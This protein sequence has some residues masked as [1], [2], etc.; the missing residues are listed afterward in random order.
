V[1]EGA[2]CVGLLTF[3]IALMAITFVEETFSRDMNFVERN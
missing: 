2:L 1:I 3:V